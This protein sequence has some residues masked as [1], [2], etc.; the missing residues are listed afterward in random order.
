[1]SIAIELVRRTPGRGCVLT[2]PLIRAGVPGVL[3]TMRPR[4]WYYTQAFALGRILAV[5]G[6]D[7]GGRVE[8]PIVLQQGKAR[9]R[10]LLLEGED[11][12]A[13]GEIQPH[14]RQCFRLHSGEGARRPRM[15]DVHPRMVDVQW[16]SRDRR[17]RRPHNMLA[18]S[19][20]L[21]CVVRAGAVRG[22]I[23]GSNQRT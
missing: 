22:S 23:F 4:Y 10:E 20:S 17:R 18:R 13:C 1:M 6:Y 21:G 3:D 2:N 5:V 12:A 16:R 15:V 9:W 8:M 7:L 14:P 19:T 11:D